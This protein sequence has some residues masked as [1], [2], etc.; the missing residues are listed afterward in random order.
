MKNTN[1][2]W[3]FIILL[4]SHISS[5]AEPIFISATDKELTIKNVLLY[6]AT[7]NV[8]AIY[9]KPLEEQLRQRIQNEYDWNLVNLDEPKSQP[10]GLDELLES[11][12]LVSKLIKDKGCDA[13]IKL[14]VS[15]GP[16]G[17]QIKLG[18]FTASGKIFSL[19]DIY[20]TDKFEID[21]LNAE[22]QKLYEAILADIPYQGLVLSR[23][24]NRV[25]INK[26]S[27]A[28]V[29][30]NSELNIVQI[31]K[32]ERHPKFNFVI[33]TQKEI[34]G[35]IR[36]VK[37]DEH[38]S[39]GTILWEKENLALQP[40]LKVLFDQPK[41][42]RNLATSENYDVIDDLENRP[43]SQ[44]MLGTKADEWQPSRM[45]TFGKID[46]ALGMG[47][48]NLGSN[49]ATTGGI[50][51][52]TVMALHMNVNSE[53]WVNPNWLLGI[54]L[55]QGGARMNNPID[56]STPSKLNFAL[57]KYNFLIG[58]NFLLNQ[59]FFGPKIQLLGGLSSF[60]SNTDDSAP[61]AFTT[62]SYSGYALGVRI[63]YPLPEH[64]RWSFGAETFYSLMPR[65]SEIPVTSGDV[66]DTKI[67]NFCGFSGYR[68]EPNTSVITK[69]S[70]DSFTT[71]FSG[72]GT[73]T[74]SASESTH[75]WT[76]LAMG[77]EFL[78]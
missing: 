50:T 59:D 30:T 49:L 31:I 23:F 3:L 1:L 7:D 78:Y 66:D 61:T 10:L 54:S 22:T 52:S 34:L 5:W 75:A 17:I 73:R 16:N 11:P 37:V 18:L 48:Y 20:K 24:D 70:Y 41:T 2:S 46:L 42:Y 36:L 53:F 14:H 40:N 8:A 13:L 74:E 56:G 43:D 76:R 72:T 21:R 39:F 65:S 64:S 9:S 28:Q 45:P 15:K 60:T 4:F 44:L 71:R 25:T 63:N 67:L 62:M 35:K 47:S 69:I 77:L 27:S 55:D 38:L 57:S 51:S 29:K 33:S 6:P 32:V 68:L 12:D 19:K 26:G 58:Y